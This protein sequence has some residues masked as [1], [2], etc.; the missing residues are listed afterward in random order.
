MNKQEAYWSSD[1]CNEWSAKDDYIEWEKQTGC[2]LKDIIKDYM[3]YIPITASVMEIGCNTGHIIGIMHELGFT[4]VCGMDIN[5]KAIDEAHKQFPYDAFIECSIKDIPLRF[6]PYITYELAMVSNVL[7]HVH[8]DD[9]HQSMDNIYNLSD[10]YIFG[11]ELYTKNEMSIGDEWNNLM[12]T[13]DTF[14][15]WITLYPSLRML[16]CNLLPMKNE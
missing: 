9:I 6:P 3:D 1:K 4:D 14:A 2:K 8:P 5:R 7:M 12:W 16:N 15:K 11:K 10:K 13:R